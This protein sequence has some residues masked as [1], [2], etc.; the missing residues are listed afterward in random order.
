MTEKMKKS[1]F[2][3]LWLQA[4]ESGKYKQGKEYLWTTGDGYCCL[5]VACVI[6]QENGVRK[7]KIGQNIEELLPKTMCNFLKMSADAGFKCPIDYNKKEYTSLADLN[8]KGIT[9]KTIA[10]I[11]REQ[12]KEKNFATR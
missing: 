6:A 8:D 2:I 9:F 5:G 12:L 7:I 3:E 10:K 1:E 4:L 11:I